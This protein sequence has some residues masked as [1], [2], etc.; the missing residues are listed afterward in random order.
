[1]SRKVFHSELFGRLIQP[2]DKDYWT[3]VYAEA[4]FRYNRMQKD[5]CACFECKRQREKLADFIE[6]DKKYRIRNNAS[7]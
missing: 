6:K 2:D 4:L 3:I 7:K 1:M 5:N